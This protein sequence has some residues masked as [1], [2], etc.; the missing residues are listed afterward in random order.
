MGEQ[1][2]R[3]VANYLSLAEKKKTTFGLRSKHLIG[4]TIR[5]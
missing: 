4:K 2:E 1:R 3:L 5:R